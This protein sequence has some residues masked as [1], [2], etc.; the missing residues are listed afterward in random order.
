MGIKTNTVISCIKYNEVSE[1]FLDLRVNASS[2]R[3]VCHRALKTCCIY[4]FSPISTLAV[5]IMDLHQLLNWFYW[6]L[7]PSRL[8]LFSR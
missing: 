1:M 5:T 8:M 2:R 4:A 6:G 7:T 3:S